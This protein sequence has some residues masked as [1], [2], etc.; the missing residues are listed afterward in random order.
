M[1]MHVP[2]L[3]LSGVL[4]TL[5]DTVQLQEGGLVLQSG[6]QNNLVEAYCKVQLLWLGVGGLVT[7]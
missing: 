2:A 3:L 5:A 7:L 6:T 1:F 4:L